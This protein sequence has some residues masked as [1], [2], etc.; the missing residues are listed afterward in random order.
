MGCSFNSRCSFKYSIY[1]SPM[2][3]LTTGTYYMNRFLNLTPLNTTKYISS[4]DILQLHIASEW[5]LYPG[6]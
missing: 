5:I 1:G 6:L 2:W 4:N 3:Y